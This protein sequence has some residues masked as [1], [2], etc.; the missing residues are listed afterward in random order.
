MHRSGLMRRPIKQLNLI[1]T[2]REYFP[3]VNLIGIR[4]NRRRDRNSDIV[5]C[6][7]PLESG[8]EGLYESPICNIGSP[9]TSPNQS[10]ISADSV[11]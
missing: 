10:K 5:F 4:R 3:K 1:F 11:K 2:R 9:P 6:P 8:D 7:P